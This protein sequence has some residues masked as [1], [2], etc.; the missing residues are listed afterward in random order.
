MGKL[1]LKSASDFAAY[2]FF[3]IWILAGVCFW[4]WPYGGL[5]SSDTGI[6][7][8]L[9]GTLF[10]LFMHF[11]LM[12]AVFIVGSLVFFLAAC[13]SVVATGFFIFGFLKKGGK[14]DSGE[15]LALIATGTFAYFAFVPSYKFLTEAYGRIFGL[16]PVFVSWI[17]DHISLVAVL[18]VL[19]I[20]FYLFRSFKQRP[21]NHSE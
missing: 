1:T 14:A 13:A 5:G 7:D 10:L 12:P 18:Y 8:V 11:W 9:F 6:F 21:D 15:L 3:W 4:K 2:T 20:A 19:P 17:S 16:V